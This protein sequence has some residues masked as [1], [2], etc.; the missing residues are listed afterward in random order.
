MCI[1]EIPWAAPTEADATEKMTA[2]AGRCDGQGLGRSLDGTR[3][4]AIFH[5]CYGPSGHTQTCFQGQPGTMTARKS[6]TY[7]RVSQ[8][9]VAGQSDGGQSFKMENCPSAAHI[10]CMISRTWPTVL[11]C[12]PKCGAGYQATQ[13]HS[14]AQSQSF[15]CQVC[16]TEVHAW[17]GA[18]D[19]LDWKA[20]EAWTGKRP[21]TPT[22]V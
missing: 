13:V 5:A 15:K 9:W 8:A 1:S 17:S 10:P 22:L 12:C 7:Q 14:P 19:F 20:V 3:L 6:R 11:F 4:G 21:Q 18:Y 16:R 2:A